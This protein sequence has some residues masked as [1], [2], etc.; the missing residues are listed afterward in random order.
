MDLKQEGSVDLIL[1]CNE[2]LSR[3]KRRIVSISMLKHSSLFV[4][5]IFAA[6]R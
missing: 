2:L 1:Q 6:A 5:I 4:I 3:N